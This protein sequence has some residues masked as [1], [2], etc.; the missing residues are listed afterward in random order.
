MHTV[1]PRAPGGGRGTASVCDREG[2]GAQPRGGALAGAAGRPRR[3]SLRAQADAS[4][5]EGPSAARCWASGVGVR[6]GTVRRSGWD[7]GPPEASTTRVQLGAGSAWAASA[8]DKTSAVSPP[9]PRVEDG[10]VDEKIPTH[11]K[12]SVRINQRVRRAGSRIVISVGVLPRVAVPGDGSPRETHGKSNR[13]LRKQEAAP[14][15]GRGVPTLEPRRSHVDR[16]L[17]DER[18][19][20]APG[21]DMKSE[22]WSVVAAPASA[23]AAP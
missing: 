8:P 5:P 11:A 13:A 4:G 12:R 16:W 6:P 21:R 3:K 2:R 15:T 17:S 19:A 23:G 18:T 10:T 20:G 7:E 1:G 9:V 22:V 14:R